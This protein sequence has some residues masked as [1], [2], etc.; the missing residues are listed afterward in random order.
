MGFLD[1]RDC[2]DYQCSCSSSN[3]CQVKVLSVA[4]LL[5]KM[6]SYKLISLKYSTSLLSSS[7]GIIC[8][9]SWLWSSHYHQHHCL[10]NIININIIII[11]LLPPPSLS[12][13]SQSSSSLLMITI[14]SLCSW[15]RN[16]KKLLSG[17]TDWNVSVWDI[18]TGEC[19]QKY[20]FQSP[21]AKVQFHPRNK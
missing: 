1:T 4:L 10:H 11:T 16:G 9:T 18:L 15:S 6:I 5:C 2:Q 8:M 21:I 7:S 13:Q 14:I 19:D 17:S 12:S 20:R 3:I